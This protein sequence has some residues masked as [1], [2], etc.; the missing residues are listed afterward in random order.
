MT[1]FY[2]GWKL[3]LVILASLPV[4]TIVSA[5]LEKIQSSFIGRENESN[6]VAGALA[7]EAIGA[8]GT[9][10]AHGGQSNEIRLYESSLKEARRAAILRG[11]IAAVRSSLL[12]LSNYGSFALAFWYGVGLVIDRESGYD[13]GSLNTIFFNTLYVVVKMGKLSPLL[14]TFT[15]A[16]SSAAGVY[17]IIYRVPIIDSSSS[18]GKQPLDNPLK[19][20]IR[21]ERVDFNYPSRPQVSVLKGLTMEIAAGRT[22]ALVGSSGCGKSTCVQLLQRFYDPN[23][24]RILI[25]GHDLTELNVAWLR[26]QIATVGQEPNLFDMSIAD[27]IRYGASSGAV[28]TQEDVERAAKTA[29][30]HQFILSLPNGYETL[31]GE[32]G[33]Q[34]SGGQKQRIAIA[35]AIVRDPKILLLDE[36]TS[37]LD[38]QSESVVQEALDKAKQG[39][40]TLIVAHRLAAIRGADWIL[41]LNQGQVVVIIILLLLLIC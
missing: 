18:S 3:S 21:F 17:Q 19:G 32:R 29:N 2:Y 38:T 25:D 27:N 33:A 8:I 28:V 11:L 26:D 30:I 34:L 41:V 14:D 39:R 20:H 24:G 6:S 7:Q 12:C 13:V 40:T 1:A 23:G 35:R 15:I 5:L 10:V 36:A 37:A 31:L 9:V 22:V 4:L 16:T